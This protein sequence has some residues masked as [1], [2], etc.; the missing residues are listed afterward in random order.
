MLAGFMPVPVDA[1]VEEFG[2]GASPDTVCARTIRTLK[3]VGVRH[4]Y[5]SNLPLTDTDA[6]LQRILNEANE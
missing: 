1:L 4:F 2:A 6:V 5:I 3:A